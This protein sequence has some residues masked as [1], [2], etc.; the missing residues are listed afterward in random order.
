MGE[1]LKNY[2]TDIADWVSS[3]MTSLLPQDM[4]KTLLKS[5]QYSLTAGG[6]RIRPILLIATL[7]SLGKGRELGLEVAS[8]IEMI[9]TYSLIHDDL[10]AMD[11]D[12]FR[13][14]IPTNHKVFGDGIAI[15]AGDALLTH[16]FHVISS[17]SSKR[18]DPIITLDLV[19]KLAI[20][21]GPVGMVGGQVL[22]LEGEHKELSLKDLEMIHRHKTGDLIHY[23]IY[24]GA[25]LGNANDEQKYA[26]TEYARKLG[27]A[28]QIQDDI[29]DVIGEEANTGKPVGSDQKRGKST[30]PAIM[31]IDAA[32]SWVEQL[33][34]E[35]KQIIELPGIDHKRLCEIADYFAK[36]EC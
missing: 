32:K 7:D 22:D 19:I 13:R 35:A 10:P 27:L 15:L 16:A 18:I 20:A 9:H 6:K 11:N 14:G 26:L 3:H 33:V 17:I 4:P 21:A 12:D 34:V 1:S 30:Y 29:L 23:S 28:F 5:M 24:A 2:M 25:V 31:G 8:A 36:R